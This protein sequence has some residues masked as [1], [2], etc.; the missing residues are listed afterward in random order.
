MKLGEQLGKLLRGGEIIEL[1]SDLG[2]GKTTFV[3]GL[4]RGAGSRDKVASPT[5]TLNRVYKA[6]GFNIYHF[7]FYRLDAPGILADQLSEAMADKAVVIVEWADIVSDILPAERLSIEFNPTPDNPDERII[8][9]K[10]PESM[11]P[12]ISATRTYIEEV[13]P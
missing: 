10:Y 2:G 6:R 11:E 3:R 8:V 9:F 1:R 5:F 7:D 13:R 4:A 12:I